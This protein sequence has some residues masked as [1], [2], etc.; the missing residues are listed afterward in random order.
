MAPFL[1]PHQRP[2]LKRLDKCS[3]C[4]E[5]IENGNGNGPFGVF[6]EVVGEEWQ[7]LQGVHSDEMRNA[8]IAHRFAP[9]HYEPIGVVIERADTVAE[10]RAH[11]KAFEGEYDE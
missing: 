4:E 6:Q 9:T 11:G 10:A 1:R 8:Q 2:A 3:D 7:H 5:P